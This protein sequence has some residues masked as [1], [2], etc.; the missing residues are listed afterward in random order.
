MANSNTLW[1]ELKDALCS[2]DIN[3]EDA[4]QYVRLIRALDIQALK[5]LKSKFSEA[6]AAQK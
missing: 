3:E 2:V 1:T 6:E 4:Q 5:D